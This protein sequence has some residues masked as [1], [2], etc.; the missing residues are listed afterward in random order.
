L[1]DAGRRHGVSDIILAGMMAFEVSFILLHGAAN[2]PL[3][4]VFIRLL[5]KVDK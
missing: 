5:T 4:T 3:Q 2:P 1:E